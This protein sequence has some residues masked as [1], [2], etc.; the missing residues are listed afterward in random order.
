MLS[1]GERVR[2]KLY[3]IMN[4]DINFIIMDEPTNHID[5][6]TRETLEEALL[7]FSGTILF[8]SHDRYFINCLATRIINIEHHH[9]ISYYGNYDD[10]LLQK[11]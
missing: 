2:L 3:E 1:G 4:Q 11:N 6:L 10:Y 8:V 5:I 9:L 7:K